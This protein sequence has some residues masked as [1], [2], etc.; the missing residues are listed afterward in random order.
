MSINLKYPLAF[1]LDGAPVRIPPNAWAWRVRRVEKG[2]LAH[3]RGGECKIVKG[4]DGGPLYMRLDSALAELIADVACGGLYRLDAVTRSLCVLREVEPVYV[5][6]P[7]KT[8][9]E[10][11][12]MT[13][14]WCDASRGLIPAL[15]RTQ[16]A[17][18]TLALEGHHANS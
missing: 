8:M 17:R 9:L 10:S 14:D 4:A 11:C 12:S 3:R 5:E 7:P 2:S 15:P 18:A 6:V 13:T 1:N 16:Q